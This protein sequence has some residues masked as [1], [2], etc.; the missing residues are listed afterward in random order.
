MKIHDL[1]YD[2]L[3]RQN[4]LKKIFPDSKLEDASDNIHQERIA[5]TIKDI[6]EEEYIKKVIEE[7]FGL[8]SLWLRV[9]MI[10]K[11]QKIKSILEMT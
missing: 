9:L 5:I 11:P 1:I 6:N 8:T 3:L 4:E 7:G 10:E 2:G